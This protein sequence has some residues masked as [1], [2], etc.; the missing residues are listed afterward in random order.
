MA[1]RCRCAICMILRHSEKSTAEACQ[2][3]GCYD[4][5]FPRS[6]HLLFCPLQH[7]DRNFMPQ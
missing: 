4:L 7:M 5:N 3:R 1:W 2:C 6:E